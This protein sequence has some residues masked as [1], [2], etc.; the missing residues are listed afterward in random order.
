MINLEA[1]APPPAP[2]RTYGRELLLN[3]IWHSANYVSK[4]LF[5]LLLTPLMLAKWGAEQYGLFALASSL[6]VSM[7][8]LDGGVRALTRIRMAEAIKAG[9]DAGFRRAFG[10]GLATFSAVAVAASLIGVALICTGLP[11]KWLHLPPGGSLTL[12]VAAVMTAIFLTT[13]LA[14]E[15]LAAWGNLSTMKAA[16]TCGALAA[17]PVCGLAV[18]SGAGVL[19]TVT[20]FSLCTIVP[21]LVVA[22]RHGIHHVFPSHEKSL[23]SPRTVFATLRSG[24]WYY[25]TT[26][27][28][29]VKTHALTFVVAA[30]AGPAEAGLFY[31]LIR[32]SEVIGNVGATASETSLASLAS[33]PDNFERSRRFRQSWQYVSLFCLNGAITL[34]LLGEPLLRLWLSGERRIAAGIGAAMAVFG[35][36]GAASRVVVNASMGLDSAKLAAQGNVAEALCDVVLAAAGYRIAGLP[37]L[38]VGASLG[39]VAMLPA[40]VRVAQRCDETFAAAYV[41]PL[42]VLLPGLALAALLQAASVRSASP[43]AWVAA[44]AMGGGIA[45]FQLRR[46]HRETR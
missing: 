37:G 42:V 8:L 17:L 14:I 38:F 28:L 9:D 32:I 20:L 31:I 24:I 43:M 13:Y 36:A 26:V 40:A 19:A 27:S 15:P 18:W 44:I 30:I 34:V 2:Q 12:A 23:F 25:L 35:L 41:K 4:A 46:L 33:A 22:V 21:N 3:Q 29:I 16:N 1:A 10:E 11:G 7:A 5:L 39:L 45:I 6:L